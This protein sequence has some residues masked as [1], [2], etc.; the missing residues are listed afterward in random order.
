MLHVPDRR[1]PPDPLFWRGIIWGLMLTA[2][3]AFIVGM[4]FA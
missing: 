1:P 4:L 2:S 3:V